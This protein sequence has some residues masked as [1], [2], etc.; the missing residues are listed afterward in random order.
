MVENFVYEWQTITFDHETKLKSK[1]E[2]KKI[3]ERS[4]NVCEDGVRNLLFFTWC[5][6]KKWKKR[7]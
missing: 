3:L 7:K 5:F 6:L 4:P 2:N 1:Q